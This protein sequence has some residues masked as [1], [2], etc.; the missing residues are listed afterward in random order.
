MPWFFQN[1]PLD[2]AQQIEQL[3]RLAFE[4][5]ESRTRL[6]R[7]YGVE[8]EGS[9]LDLVRSARLP[10][11]PAYEHYLGAR[12]LAQTREAIRSEL[13]ILLQGVRPV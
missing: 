4:L 13:K 12:I 10:E 2:A 6:L 3:S 8:D 11:H 5:R 9:L 7:Q 1:L